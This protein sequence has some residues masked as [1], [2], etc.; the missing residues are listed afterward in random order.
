MRFPGASLG[1]VVVLAA[2][3]GSTPDDTQPRGVG[4]GDVSSYE[5]ERF[6]RDAALEGG[7]GPDPLAVS[8]E[9]VSPVT[10]NNPLISDEQD[11]EAVAGRET[12]ES[13]AERRARQQEAYVAIEPTALPERQG[14]GGSSIVDF[15]LSTTNRVG[16]SIYRRSGGSESRAARACARY[17]SSDQ[18]QED[19][20]SS[21]GPERD[22]KGVD[23]DGDGFA[24]FWD[25]TPF[26]NARG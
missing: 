1:L 26:R 20:L 18:A 3:G 15:A 9:E 12:I 25:P 5:N 6:E 14:S 13:D 8:D 22:R 17:T 23:P 2:C 4:F 21:G 11:F 19:F 16:E 10:T 7:A 24:C